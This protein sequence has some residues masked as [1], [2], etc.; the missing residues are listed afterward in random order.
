MDKVLGNFLIL[1]ALS[2]ILFVSLVIFQVPPH[3]GLLS[4]IL[5]LL[6]VGLLKGY[7]W[8]D[9]ETAMAD[10]I[11]VA[12][13][14]IFILSMIG[15]IVSIWMMS[16]TIPSILYFGMKYIS[17]QWFYLSSI[18]ICILTSS[19]NGSSVGTVSTVGVALIGIAQVQGLPL[20]IAAAAIICGACFGDKCSPLSETTN[21]APGIFQINLYDHV[22]HLA[23]TTIPA[24]LLT[25]ICF[26]KLSPETSDSATS[27]IAATMAVLDD[28]FCITAATF[29]SPLLVVALAYYKIPA[30]ATFIVG[31]LSGLLTAIL[32]QKSPIDIH[33]WAQVAQHGFKLDNCSNQLVCDLVNRGGLQSMMWAISLVAIALILGGL[34]NKL[35]IISEL[36]NVLTT[37]LHNKGAITSVAALSCI[38]I[39]FLSGE[40]YLS[41]VLPG[42]A[43]QKVYQ[44]KNLDLKD[45]ARTL[46][47]CGTLVNPLV[48]WGV[49]GAF[50]S[51][52]LGVS[53]IEY[54]P[55]VYFLYFSPIINVCLSFLPKSK[56]EAA[57]LN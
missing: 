32:V 44:K 8:D 36:L 16:G 13:K 6:F 24:L 37:T 18:L 28:T 41:I 40:Q 54:L 55:Y 52:A 14:P 46:E 31:I 39:N 10:G 27:T 56:E 34:L 20:P 15:I 4:S 7:S 12:L 3:I 45:L 47:D 35:K 30:L 51:A 21:L 48:P 49:C 5:L 9:L 50:Y 23:G 17:P 38:F 19:F 57:A 11:Y 42:Q 29:A 1:V 43:F 53:V 2:L 22:K 25:V 33:Y 26:Y